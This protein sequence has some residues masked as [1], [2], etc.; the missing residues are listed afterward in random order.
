M[1]CRE[2]TITLKVDIDVSAGIV[3]VCTRIYG[4]V[5]REESL[6]RAEVNQVLG[7]HPVVQEKKYTQCAERVKNVINTYAARR[8]NMLGYLRSLA[9]N[10]SF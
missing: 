8:G 1:N 6:V 9:H 2:R 5:Q 10:L 4:S 7:G 3:I